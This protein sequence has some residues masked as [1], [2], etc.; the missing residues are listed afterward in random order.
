MKKL[1]LGL[2]TFI[3]MINVNAKEITFDVCEEDNCDFK[4]IDDALTRAEDYFS[5]DT[6]NIILKDDYKD[7]ELESHTLNSTINIVNR[8]DKK[9]DLIEIKGKNDC[10]I[11]LQNTFKITNRYKNTNGEIDIKNVTFNIK[12]FRGNKNLLEFQGEFELKNIN[13]DGIFKWEDYLRNINNKEYNAEEING[14]VF[15]NSKVV[16]DGFNINNFLNGIINKNTKLSIKNSDLSQ[17]VYS[18]YN[19]YGDVILDFTKLNSIVMGKGNKSNLKITGSSEFNNTVRIQSKDSLPNKDYSDIILLNNSTYNLDLEVKKNINIDSKGISLKRVF[20]V[21]EGIDYNKIN[22]T[23]KD[24]NIAIIN[25]N[26]LVPIGIGNTDIISKVNDNVI[27]KV[28]VIVNDKSKTFTK[29]II[30]MVILVIVVSIFKKR[31]ES[32]E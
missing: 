17:N 27:L 6:I 32:N 15:N 13:L 8:F 19:Y 4:N 28:H 30:G 9:L 21:I 1:L 31:N 18:I 11:T 2:L 29:F 5:T 10:T 23:S 25:D 14:I 7:Y 12:E 22:W 24:K 3:I 20:P 26:K 16:V